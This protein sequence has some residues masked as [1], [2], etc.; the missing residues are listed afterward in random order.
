MRVNLK[1]I[2]EAALDISINDRQNFQNSLIPILEY[3]SHITMQTK[4]E[5]P[6][7]AWVTGAVGLAFLALSED[8]DN[9]QYEFEKK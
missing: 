4:L 5:S 7:I 9:L 6:I 3:F 8:V 2:S 1:R